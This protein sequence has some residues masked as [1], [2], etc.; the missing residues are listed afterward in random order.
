MEEKNKYEILG[1]LFVIIAALG[2]A[3]KGILVKLT[4]AE[5]VSVPA[6]MLWRYGGASIIFILF[7]LINYKKH[8]IFNHSR[9]SIYT[10]LLAGF[11]G[12]YLGTYADYRGLELLEATISRF[13]L[14]T[15]PV[16]V[17]FINSVI[18]RKLPPVRQ[19]LAILCIQIGMYFLL[20]I[21]NESI[22]DLNI[23]GILW[24]L[25][26]AFVYAIYLILMHKSTKTFSSIIASS[27]IVI[28]AL[29]VTTIEFHIAD[30]WEAEFY[31][32]EKA[33][34]LLMLT[35][36]ISTFL[37]IMLMAE[38]I[39][40]LGSSRASIISASSPFLTIILAFILL[41][42][43]MTFYQLL[44]GIIIFISV[45]V[46]EGKIPAKKLWRRGV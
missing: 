3:F 7:I 20:I 42:E 21:E 22:E 13:I 16:F 26:A 2:F 4:I 10:I 8:N 44:G 40:R 36:F 31:I 38:A 27:Y 45:A 12:Y 23:E 39:K 5:G 11:F 33:F 43:I 6:L 34:W 15:F 24:E 18:E 9:N 14:F 46:L 17:I 35:A 28:F 30:R 37:P 29:I 32:S 25:L 41:D 1:I 19:I